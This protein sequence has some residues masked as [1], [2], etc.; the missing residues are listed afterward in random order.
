MAPL[1]QVIFKKEF[2]EVFRDGRTRYSVILSPLLITPLAMALIGAMI[3]DRTESSVKE[4]IPVVFVGTKASPVLRDLMKNPQNMNV[5][6]VNTKAEA[7]KLIH[8]QKANAALVFPSDTE[9]AIAESRQV[10]VTVLADQGKESSQSAA[11]KLSNLVEE[12]GKR[13]VALKLQENGLPQQLATPFA[14]VDENIKGGGSPGTLIASSFL[15]YILAIYAIIGGAYLANDTVAGEKE[16]GTL[17]TLLVSPASR[18]EIVTGK[19]VAVVSVS[20]IGGFLSV[21]GFL[22]PIKTP[23]VAFSWLA[24]A[25]IALSPSGILAMF[26]VQIPLAILG[27]GLLLTISTFARTQREAQSYLSPVM[28]VTTICAMMSLV[29]KSESPIVWAFVPITNAALVLKQSLEGTT[30]LTFVM[31]ACGTS[32]LYA[33]CA[34]TFAAHAFQKE[35]ILLKA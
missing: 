5:E 32:L 3:K 19:F 23:L 2:F 13:L 4:T 34:V 18:R 8:D 22:W 16:R 17:E 10:I 27:A 35:S 26:L 12:R 7:A 1:W 25:G 31:V 29:L 6:E 30:N 33:A 11:N 28:L 20:I 24:K 14:S 9:Q 21:I 15:P